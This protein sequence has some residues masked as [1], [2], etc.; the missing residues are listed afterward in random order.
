MIALDL[1]LGAA[2]AFGAGLIEAIAGGGGLILVPALFA[3]Y[4]GAPPATL[5][6][7]NK[8]AALWGT[9]S[10]AVQ[11]G[12]RV[13]IPWQAVRPACAAALVGAFTGAWLVTQINSE[14]LRWALPAVLLAVLSHTLMNKNL[15]AAHAPRCQGRAEIIATCAIGAVIGFYDGLFGPGTGSFFVFVLVRGLGY[16][17]LHAAASAKVLNTMTNLSALTLFAFKGHVWWPTAAVM[18][19]A[20]LLGSLIGTRV[21]LRHGSA[22]VRKVFIGV[23]SALIA[24]TAWDSLRPLLN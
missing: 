5:L 12:R 8:A 2:A 13:Q 11:Y 23:V 21:A 18:A 10:A 17:F 24:K 4:P 7:T 16:D 9:A 22:L 6:G 3:V 20:H 1:L 19:C 14:P 15:G